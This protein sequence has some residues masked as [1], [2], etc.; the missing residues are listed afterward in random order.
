MLPIKLTIQGFNSYQ[1]KQEIDFSNLL[2][3]KVFGIFGEVGSGKSSILEAISFALY[4]QI[5]KMNK[6]DGINY[7]LMNLKSDRLLLDFEFETASGKYRFLVE[8]KRNSKNFENVL[9]KRKKY[10][11][12][13]SEWIPNDNLN[14]E[15]IIGLSYQNFKRTIIIPQGKFMEFIRLKDADRTKMLKEIFSLQ[16]YDL[17][18]KVGYLQK[19]N[20]EDIANIV[21]KLSQFENV[22]QE[23]LNSSENSIDLLREER[24]GKEKILKSNENEY[25]LKETLKNDFD[26]LNAKEEQYKQLQNKKEKNIQKEKDLLL[27]EKCYLT[28]KPLFD[29]KENLH[30]KFVTAKKSQ[31]E[32]AEKSARIKN[33][34]NTKRNDFEV[35]KKDFE[36]IDNLKKQSSELEI[37]V[38]IK[39]IEEN[40]L[41]NSECLKKSKAKLDN[42]VKNKDDIYTRL[43]LLDK[44]IKSVEKE[45]PDI[46]LLSQ[47]KEWFVI[48][49]SI[50]QNISDLKQVLRTN[51]EALKL[52]QKEKQA[53]VSD[54]DNQ[55]FK[56]DFTADISTI[57]EEIENKTKKFDS[58]LKELRKTREELMVKTKLK[59]YSQSLK[60]GTPCPVCGS[61]EHPAPIVIEHLDSEIVAIEKRISNGENIVE[62]LRNYAKLFYNLRSDIENV[63]KQMEL[64]KRKLKDKE[65]E[66]KAHIRKYVWKEFSPESKEE[67]EKANK[68][69]TELSIQLKELRSQYDKLLIEAKTAQKTLDDSKESHIKYEDEMSSLLAAQNAFLEQLNTLKYTDYIGETL[70][71]ISSQNSALKEK[72]TGI[73]KDYKRLDQE[74]KNL[75]IDS[76]VIET[77]IETNEKLL[78]EIKEDEEQEDKKIKN[79]LVQNGF[80]S[81]DKVKTILSSKLD[82]PG[83][84]KEIEKF[85]IYYKTTKNEVEKL[86]LKLKDKEFDQDEFILLKEKIEKGKSELK[87]LDKDIGGLEKTIS[88]LKD[89]L[90][91]KKKFEAELN[92]KQIR[93]E[94]LKTMRSL[95]TGNGFVNYISTVRLQEVVNYANSRFIKLTRGRM[96]LELTGNNSFDIIDFLNGGKRRNIKTLSGGQTFQASLSLAL[97]L[98]SIVQQQNKSE[99]NFFFL[100]EGFGTQDEES[101]RMVF[102]AIKEL[103]KEN[104][105]IGLISHV[106]E[107]KE[108]I[109]TFLEVINDD[110][111]GSK[112]ITSW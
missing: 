25:R 33:Q 51:Q 108:E 65:N 69:A 82:I 86:R 26:S 98:A 20:N 73:E 49:Q 44:N 61:K 92:S 54:N 45:L 88:E 12:Q 43:D 84:K 76:K 91:L 62:K 34:L 8:G 48:K 106:S 17:L 36:N 87:Q 72:I 96:K 107:L 97:A 109:N 104:R 102:N 64:D 78:S 57:I 89:K 23:K 19:Q 66:L 2:D 7:N 93:Q 22:T 6:S 100:D 29:N 35:I 14:A 5:E 13:G 90:I 58:G 18:D 77:K 71:Q 37:I 79:L 99:Q 15:E 94:D 63:I 110:Q 85:K 28:F 81:I 75:E 41:A 9:I 103:R 70:K 55:I 67:V 10:Q 83:L 68:T 1:T 112:V 60:E 42:A 50:L 30:R 111:E 47:I 95:F 74:I 52:K 40:I 46:N 16:K 105:T 31:E 27:Y 39:K 3:S 32:F 21:G 24:K 11:W 56:I 80:D 53:I 101:L 38:S 59:D 4:G